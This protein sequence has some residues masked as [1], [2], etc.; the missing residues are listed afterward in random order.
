MLLAVALPNASAQGLSFVG[1]VFSRNQ[2][3]TLTTSGYRLLLAQRSLEVAKERPINGWGDGTF[4][5]I[6]INAVRNGIPF[7]LTSPDNHFVRVLV[8]TG[9][10]GFL[11][12]IALMLALLGAALRS[13][14]SQRFWQD[15]AV[16]AAIV[17]ALVGFIFVNISFGMF[18]VD[19]VTFVFWILAAVAVRLRLRDG[20]TRVS[21][22]FGITESS[23]G[24]EKG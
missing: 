1:D 24:V 19:Q 12:F 4:D 14:A 13:V 15:R 7:M 9:I 22:V 21:Q 2:D 18:P 11:A 3:S 20:D 16:A 10:V 23:A 17:A 6:G 5:R 8:E